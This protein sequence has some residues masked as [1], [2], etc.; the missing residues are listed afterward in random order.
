[1]HFTKDMKQ[2]TQNT[3]KDWL[4]LTA[5]SGLIDV[6]HKTTP[7]YYCVVTPGREIPACLIALRTTALLDSGYYVQT[8]AKL[9]SIE[10]NSVKNSRK[11]STY[12][13]NHPPCTTGN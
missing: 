7:R 12:N 2:F 3:E 5:S 8:P 9:R 13:T 1:M 4:P 6:C 10:G 11:I